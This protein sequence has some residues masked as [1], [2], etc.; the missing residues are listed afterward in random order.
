MS[1]L[2]N[3]PP[4]QLPFNKKN[5]AWR[6]RHLD[7]A[8]S[9]TFFNY[10]LVRKSVIH[11]KINYDLFNGKLH[12]TDLELILN[13]ED[14]KAGFIPSRI[15]HY[16]IMNSKLSVLRGEES[17]RI[18]DFRVIVTNPN[19]ISEVENNKKEELFQRL[20]QLIA[21]T[22]QSEEEFNQELEKLNDYYTYEWQDVREIRANALLNHYIKEYNIP[23][24]SM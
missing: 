8:D 7:W 14:I 11:K 9:K 17:K 13:P 16:P 6:K 23:L 5:K 2:I 21:N 10:S 24:I 4:Q 12:M 22:S 1:E 18:F 19:A 20:Q 15:Q 3:L